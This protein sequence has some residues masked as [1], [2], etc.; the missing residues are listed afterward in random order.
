MA[1]P[2]PQLAL[3]AVLV[4]LNAAFAGTELAL[5]SLRDAQLQRLEASSARGAMLARLA[6]R[7]N[8][9]LATIQIGITLAGFLASAAAA[10]SLAEPLEEPL[11]LLGD[12]ARPVS[13]F[14]VTIAL[15][16]VTLVF[17]ELVP[18]RIALQRAEAWAML[19]ARPLV[20]LTAIARPA[21]WLLSHSTDVIV[22]LLGADPTRRARRSPTTNCARW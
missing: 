13:V 6:G 22:R 14:V 20:A 17:G 1:E 11:A 18:K 10:V 12:A 21:V 4:V 5:V 9:Y 8:Q 16:Y 15:A 7:P 19:M 3:I 2:I